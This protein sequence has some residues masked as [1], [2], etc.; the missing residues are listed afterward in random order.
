MVNEA[1]IAKLLHRAVP[2]AAW[3]LPSTSEVH[4]LAGGMKLFNPSSGEEGFVFYPFDHSVAQPLIITGG[5]EEHSEISYPAA[6]FPPGNQADEVAG[7][8]AYQAQFDEVLDHIKSGEVSKLVLSRIIE[9]HGLS[10][11]EAS[12]AFFALCSRYPEAFVYVFSDGQHEHWMGAS[13]ETLVRFTGDHAFTM[14]LAGTIPA[15]QGMDW[16]AKEAE[17][18]QIVT[19]FIVD[20]LKQAGAEHVEIGKTKESPAGR[21]VHLKTEIRFSLT[22]NTS[23]LGIVT[24]LHPTPAVCGSP[25]EAALPLIR[26]IEKHRRRYYAGFL[27]PWSTNDDAWLFV[28]LRCMA[29]SATRSL[30]YVGGGI[31]AGSDVL[32]EWNETAWKSGTLSWLFEAK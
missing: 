16:T 3:R 4:L 7:F 10:P 25:R 6:G 29:F 14:S 19:D 5:M 31:T 27:G 8:S 30:L 15:G 17:E 12:R 21:L 1:Q 18:Q 9:T 24:T 2:F 28:N 26:R 11:D 20:Q 22:A 13:P 32:R 23:R